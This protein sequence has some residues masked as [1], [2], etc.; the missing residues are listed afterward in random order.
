MS[1]ALAVV[2]GRVFDGT[3]APPVEGGTVVAEGGRIAAVGAAGEAPVPKGA[4]V[5]DAGGRV[6]LPGLVEGHSH[7]PGTAVGQ[8]WLRLSLQRGIT[9]VA[10]VSANIRGI[11]LRDGIEAG[12]VRGCARLIAGCIVTPTNGH[13]KFRAADGPWE[14]RKAVREMVQE[15]ADFIKTAASGGFYSPHETCSVRNYTLEELEAL[16]DEAHAW[17]LPVVC[18]VHTQPGLDNCVA[19]EVD[20]VHHGGFIDE[21]AVRGIREKNLFYMPTLAVTC[22]RNIRA[23]ADQP[24]QTKE[25]AESQPVHRAGV[26]LA[27]QLGVRLAVG[28]DYPGTPKGWRIG[29]RTMYELQ[30]L[31][32]CGLTPTEALVAATKTNAEAYRKQ[33]EIGTLAPGKRADIIVAEGDPFADVAAL[34]PPENIRVVVKDGVVE[35]ASGEYAKHYRIGEDQPADRAGAL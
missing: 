7:V 34:Y 24:W 16:T 2:N 29:D 33:D 10:S 11:E 18:H 25:M 26:R 30:E 19:A 3:G 14:V 12:L 9:T 15:R 27:H 28:C 5:V 35:Y 17:G 13:V 8:K 21:K 4:E 20:Q 6:V 23:L 22:D 1:K 31:V 32:A